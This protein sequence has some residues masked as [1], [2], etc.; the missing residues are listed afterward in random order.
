MN[1]PDAFSIMAQAELAAR[2][3]QEE[4]WWLL[5]RPA[6]NGASAG[7]YSAEQAASAAPMWSARIRAAVTWL[8]TWRLPAAIRSRVA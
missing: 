5:R 8:A 7:A 6:L 2:R 1:G 3:Q 4:E